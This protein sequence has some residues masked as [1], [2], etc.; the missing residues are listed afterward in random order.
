MLA[1][2]QNLP[3]SPDPAPDPNKPLL[4]E[5]RAPPLGP[6]RTAGPASH[7]QASRSRA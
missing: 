4:P 2:P 1:L 5:G 3:R 6:P 7:G